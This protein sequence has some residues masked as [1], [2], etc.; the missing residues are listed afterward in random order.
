MGGLIDGIGGMSGEMNG[1]IYMYISLHHVCKW[2]NEE[3]SRCL[4]DGWV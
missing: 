3:V 4:M 2:N 1:Y